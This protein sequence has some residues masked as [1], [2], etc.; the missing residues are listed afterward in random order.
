MEGLLKKLQLSEE[1]KKSIR[2]E[3][4]LGGVVGDRPVQAVGK[5]L[6]EK[7]VRLEIIEQTVGWIWCPSRG[8]ECKDL[9][10]NLFLFTFH[11]PSG[12][13]K[14][15]EDG[16]WAISK[17]LL[18]VADFDGSKSI[19]EVEFSTIP[20]WIRVDRLPMGMMNEAVAKV[21]GDEVGKFM[22][23]EAGGDGMATGRILRL[24]VRLDIRKPLRRGIL[25]S[26]GEGK[27]DRWCPF[28]YELLPEFCYVCGV[29]G[30]IDRICS[31]KLNPGEQAPF[32]RELHFIPPRRRPGYV[33]NRSSGSWRSGSGGSWQQRGASGSGGSGGSDGRFRSDAPSWR[34]TASVMIEG[35]KGGGGRKDEEEVTS[36]LKQVPGKETDSG[37]GAKK[38]LLPSLDASSKDGNCK[39]HEDGVLGN[40]NSA[41]QKGVEVPVAGNGK[42]EKPRTPR[43]FERQSRDVARK[44]EKAG[45]EAIKQKKRSGEE[46]MDI[47]EADVSGSKKRRM[48]DDVVLEGNSD[49]EAEL[50]S[51][52]REPQ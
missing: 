17:E 21:I 14:A 18:V 41:M 26:M 44:G 23:M 37:F 25:M 50:P 20:I 40:V 2:V 51:Q 8:I 35:K 46:A 33:E 4:G 27:E 43:R 9:G 1:E 38:V 45:R 10:E 29:I 36:P 19:D 6:S 7:G 24:K 34:K 47:E 15:L 31:K 42:S 28:A 39:E 16:P 49:V 48:G 12:K 52:L 3:P 30:H 11:Q 13:R 22:E 5:L 32:S